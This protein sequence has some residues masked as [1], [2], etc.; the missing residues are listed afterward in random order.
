MYKLLMSVQLMLVCCLELAV[1]SGSLIYIEG[2]MIS[3]YIPE[4]NKT[5]YYSHDINESMQKPSLGIDSIFRAGSGMFAVQGRVAYDGLSDKSV[6]QVYNLYYKNKSRF[7][8]I[9]IG[10]NRP[11]F[12]LSSYLDSH[13]KLFQP[14][15]MEGF[16]Y[17]RDWGIGFYRQ[18][19]AGDAS[20][21]CTAG[22]G[23]SFYF[24][25][26][27][28]VNSRVSYGILEKD[29]YSF[30]LSAG[31]GK[32][33]HFMGAEKMDDMLNETGSAGIDWNYNINNFEFKLESIFSRAGGIASSGNLFRVG[34]NFLEEDRLKIEIQPVSVSNGSGNIEKLY[35]G[36]TYVI[37][38][39]LNARLMHVYNR[40]N[41]GGMIVTQLY[42]YKKLY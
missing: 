8:D 21:S 10:H 24:D 16:G 22:S 28:L 23:M 41:S 9:W 40:N 34:V 25:N 14:L 4:N 7:G 15:S 32:V 18:Y 6:L 33:Y 19:D 35:S 5:V 12:G 20:I 37:N 29:N 3:G 26:N 13:A 38:E 27:F 36:I 1:G 2:Q 30:G 42:Y 11:A 39:Y 17:D 31:Y